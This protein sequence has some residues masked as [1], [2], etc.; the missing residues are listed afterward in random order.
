MSKKPKYEVYLATDGK[1]WV[2]EPDGYASGPYD[3]SGD[4]YTAAGQK[5]PMPWPPKFEFYKAD[6][7]WWFE[8]N[9]SRDGTGPYSSKADMEEDMRG[10]RRFC[11][12]PEP[13][14]N[15]QTGLMETNRQW[16]EDYYVKYGG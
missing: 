15:H 9:I 7:G 2:D 16:L 4:A 1:W 13:H 3:H 8:D 5:H 12:D 14:L 10:R 6:D 11:E